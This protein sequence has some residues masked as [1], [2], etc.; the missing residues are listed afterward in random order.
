MPTTEDPTATAVFLLLSWLG[1]E[2]Y[3][4]MYGQKSGTPVSLYLA[5]LFLVGM[6][7][8]WMYAS[9]FIITQFARMIEWGF[10]REVVTGYAALSPEVL[11][12]ISR[13]SFGEQLFNSLAFFLFWGFSFIGSFY[14]LSKR[15]GNKYSFL[16]ALS[17]SVLLAIGFFGLLIGRSALDERWWHFAQIL[18]AIP[19]ILLFEIGLKA[20]RMSEKR[21]A[22]SEQ[23]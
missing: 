16:L 14:L 22:E 20:A 23:A 11:T 5:S 13:I 9:G 19:M 17:G 10:A 7:G 4:R 15:F 6:L 2:A 21:R 1:F 18:L 12:S 3:Q 8:W